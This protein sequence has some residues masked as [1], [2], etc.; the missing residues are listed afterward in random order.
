MTAAQAA[1]IREGLWLGWQMAA[2][3]TPRFSYIG[4]HP[5]TIRAMERTLK[6]MEHQP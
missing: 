4:T 6:Q 5:L 1:A 2:G 3:H